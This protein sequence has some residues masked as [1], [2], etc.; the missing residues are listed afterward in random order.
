[1]VASTG[2]PASS[3][4]VNI[5][6]LNF[7][8]TFPITSIQSSFD[9][10]FSSPCCL[11]RQVQNRGGRVAAALTTLGR[12]DPT[13]DYYCVRRPGIHRRP[14]RAPASDGLR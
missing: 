11:A 5:P 8:T 1:M 12:L 6:A 3:S 9:K 13:S 14:I 10:F 2:L 4:T 7:S